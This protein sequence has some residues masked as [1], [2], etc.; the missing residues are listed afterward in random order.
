M[1]TMR[2][3]LTCL[4]MVALLGF[5]SCADSTAPA[6]NNNN[7]NNNNN[8]K[9]YAPLSSGSSW[10]YDDVILDTVSGNPIPS[11]LTEETDSVESSSTVAGKQNA[12]TIVSYRS[13]IETDS[14]IVT[15]STSSFDVYM[16]T[17]FLE[18][19]IQDT[20]TSWRTVVDFSKSS[21]SVLDTNLASVTFVETEVEGYPTTVK[22]TGN[23]KVTG[24]KGSTT[25]LTIDGKSVTAQEFVVESVINATLL[26]SVKYSGSDVPLPND[27]F[28]PLTV[29]SVSR[30]WF[31]E[32]IGIVKSKDEPYTVSASWKATTLFGFIPIPA[33]AQEEKYFGNERTLIRYNITK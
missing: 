23:L 10:T 13:G 28:N 26:G 22:A 9:N 7:N 33:G 1:V 30:I 12:Y 15:S 17:P 2:S 25:T 19:F 32:N 8:Q 20:K 3:V 27:F 6:D 11:S 24:T 29:K 31:A 14:K 16:K 5:A 18:Q 21:W 4:A